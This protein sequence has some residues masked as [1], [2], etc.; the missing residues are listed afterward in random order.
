VRRI[1]YLKVGDLIFGLLVLDILVNFRRNLVFILGQAFT[2]NLLSLER[3]Q[4]LLSIIS[5]ELW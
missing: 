5:V 4:I 2:K 3:V 1:F